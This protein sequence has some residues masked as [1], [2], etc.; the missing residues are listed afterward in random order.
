[1]LL[2]SLEPWKFFSYMCV[3]LLRYYLETLFLLTLG[4]NLNVGGRG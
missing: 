4:F 3:N 2:F 1:M